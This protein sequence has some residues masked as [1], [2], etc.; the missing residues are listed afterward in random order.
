MKITVENFF[1]YKIILIFFITLL[2]PVGRLNAQWKNVWMSAGSLHNWYSEIGSELEEGFVL[3]QQY[4]MQWPAFYRYQDMQAARGWWIGCK[5]FTDEKGDFYPYKVVTVGPRN[6]Q[7]FAAYP[8]QMEMVGKFEPTVVNVDG[9]PSTGKDVVIDRYDPNMPSDRMIINKVATQLGVTME[10][11]I[12]Q[13]SQQYHD[14]YIVYEYIFTNTGDTDGD[15]TT[16]E[17]PNNTVTDMYNFWTYRNAVNQSTRNVIGNSTGWGENTM[18]DARGDL[19]PGDPPD[20]VGQQFR[21]QF[22]WHG[23]AT[24]KIVSYDNI[25]APIWDLSAPGA[26]TYNAKDDTIGRLGGTQFLGVATLYADKSPTEKVDDP[27]QP[28]RTSYLGSDESRFLAGANAFNIDQM[29][30]KYEYMARTGG[31]PH[32]KPRHANSVEPSGDFAKQVNNPGAGSGQGGY[33]F[34]NSYG[35]YTL[36]PG[37]SIRIVM[38]EGAAGM[39]KADQI[40]YGRL[41]KA[42]QLSAY[43]KNTLVIN[44]GRDSLFTTF[45]RATENFKAGWNIPSP[46]KPPVTFDVNSGGDR[47]TLAWTV[48]GSDPNPPTAFRIYRALGDFDQEYTMIAE[49][50]AGTTSYDDVNLI[51][52]FNYFYY[53]TCVGANQPG[54]PSTPA[55]RLESNRN[56]T[57]TYTAANLQRPAGKSLSEIRIVPNPY[58]IDAAGD[59]RFPGTIDEDKIAFFNIPGNCTIRIYTEL[60]ELINTIEHTNGSGDAYWYS[61]TS[62]N[63]IIVSGIYIAV[64]TDNKSGENHIAKFAIIR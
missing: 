62:S 59:V 29:T 63:Q 50:P 36:A 60:G 49:L 41:F 23:Y 16:I 52:G 4:G 53:M 48:D 9:V 44:K 33:S 61:V 14:N 24:T 46:P 13:F 56:Y 37:Q 42:G 57:Q 7:F 8:I 3:R 43:D 47:I 40:R 58:I 28:S 39:N 32:Q 1:R 26:L 54:D 15:T 27:S 34:N 12:F 11:R 25:G 6:P 10:R 20:P 38:V 64:I 19:N 55:G 18:N 2:L 21:C 17:L 45:Q 35:P 22:S 5:N 51:R 30:D 31:L